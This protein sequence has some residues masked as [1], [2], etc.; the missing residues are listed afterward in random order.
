LVGKQELPAPLLVPPLP[1][2]AASFAAMQSDSVT[3]LF[4]GVRG[5]QQATAFFGP[6]FLPHEDFAEFF[7]SCLMPASCFSDLSRP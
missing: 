6:F 3:M 2:H 4:S 7:F 5:R 1:A